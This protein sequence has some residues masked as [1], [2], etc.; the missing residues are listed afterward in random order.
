EVLKNEF[1]EPADFIVEFAHKCIDAGASAVIGGGTHQLKPI[2]IYKGYAIFYSLGNFIYQGKSVKYQPADFYEKYDVPLDYNTEEA[3]NVRS[4]G[5]TIGIH[6]DFYNYMTFLPKMEFNAKK[7]TKLSLMPV[8]LGFEKDECLNGLPC[9]AT[10]KWGEKIFNHI[11]KL[12]KKN[13]VK[14]N[15]VNGYIEVEV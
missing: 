13:S 8:E 15:Y 12:S 11:Q 5:D 4:K 9:F 6:K 10:G 3:L 1:T 14:M 2:E 7:L